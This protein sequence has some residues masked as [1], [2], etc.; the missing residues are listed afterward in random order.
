MDTI[1]HTKEGTF[2]SGADL[3]F[4]R[5]GRF[6][7]KFQNFVFFKSTE[8]IFRAVP[9][10]GLVPVLVPVLRRRQNFEKTVQKKLFG[11]F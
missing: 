1:K 2:G 8:L 5:G 7:K 11:K 3:G 4:C 9:K 10:Q 6:S